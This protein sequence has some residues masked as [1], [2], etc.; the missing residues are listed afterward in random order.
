MRQPEFAASGTTAWPG[1]R[2]PVLDGIRGLAI[3][4]VLFHH[5]VIYS[6]MTRG[7][8]LD[9][10]V[11]RLGQTSWIGVD[12]F[13]VL[14]GFLITG[15]LYDHK[16]SQH[17]F[18]DFFGRRALRIFPLYFTFL[19]GSFL[20]LPLFLAADTGLAVTA[21]QAWYWLYASNIQ[22]AIH[23]WPDQ[24][25]FGHFWSLGVEE[26]YYLVWPFVVYA[27]GR[28]GL[29]GISAL[30]LA[31][32]LVLRFLVPL[33]LDPLANY[34]LMPTRMD[35]F[36]AGAMV[37]LVV[38]GPGGL[39]TLGSW[40]I[41]LFLA[42]LVAL[43]ILVPMN[44]KFSTV[45]VLYTV[46]FS[47][48]ATGFAALIALLLARPPGALLR[49]VFTNSILLMLGKYSYALYVFHQPILILMQD[50]GLGVTMLPSLGGSLLPGL[51]MFS[52]IGFVISLLC[53]VISWHLIE[54]PFL[55]LKRH[56]SSRQPISRDAEPHEPLPMDASP[57]PDA[58]VGR[59]LQRSGDCA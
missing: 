40:P 11:Q 4:L 58:I 35:A 1:G 48:V 31:G 52:A 9:S 7:H 41:L 28:R 38:R 44:R 39:R 20:V 18:R 49:R 21:G 34:V 19:A 23:G 46:G 25:Y 57:Y 32:A 14:S 42:S 30:C 6:G 8:I 37:A 54:T 24:L 56:F 16:S 59:G 45:P 43:S 2:E 51:I 5:F 33:W 22:V 26:Q 3:A 36:A 10:L 55:R 13:F 47:V 15:I 29:L 27:F 12:L 53:A 17:Y 50:Y